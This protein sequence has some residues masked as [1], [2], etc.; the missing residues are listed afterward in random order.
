MSILRAD[1]IKKPRPGEYSHGGAL[2][3][4]SGSPIASKSL[5]NQS[6]NAGACL[7]QKKRKII[8]PGGTKRLPYLS[9]GNEGWV[10][11]APVPLLS[12]AASTFRIN[13]RPNR[14]FSATRVP[15]PTN[16]A[17]KLPRILFSLRLLWIQCPAQGTQRHRKRIIALAEEQLLG[18]RLEGSD[19]QVV[20]RRCAVLEVQTT[21]DPPAD[22]AVD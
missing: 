21:P 9:E 1:V 11:D 16:D 19:E 20:W 2:T 15:F 12:M 6:T 17:A 10:N 22:Q 8:A 3:T 14:H 7:P 5:N 4:S 13:G 18:P